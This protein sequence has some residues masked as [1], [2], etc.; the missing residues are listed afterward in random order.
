MNWS[1]LNTLS[2]LIVWPILVFYLCQY[3]KKIFFII[4]RTNWGCYWS[5]LNTL[6]K[7]IVW[8]ILVFYLCQYAKEI[9]FIIL[10]TNWGCYWWGWVTSLYGTWLIDCWWKSDDFVYYILYS[11]FHKQVNVKSQSRRKKGVTA[12]KR[13]ILPPPPSINGHEI[14]PTGSFCAWSHPSFPYFPDFISLDTF[15]A[16]AQNAFHC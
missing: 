4:L 14:R 9:F 10:R 6:S 13:S 3:A 5:F 2:K 1:F 16:G 7:L 12:H 11:F 15:K 8:P